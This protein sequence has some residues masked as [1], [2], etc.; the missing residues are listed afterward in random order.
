[1]ERPIRVLTVD[2]HPIV[3][4][5]LATVLNQEADLDVVG[6][7]E[8]GAQAVAAARRLHP[9]VVL[10]DL[11]MPIMDGVEAIQRIQQ[12]TPDTEVIILTT[13]DTDD[14]IFRGVE[15]GAKAYLLK[16]S[17][18][19]EVLRA[20]RMVHRGESLIEP[21]VASRLLDRF[22]QLSKAPREG[23]LSAREVEVVELIAEGIGNK[24]IA[25]RLTIGEST[26]KT[27]LIHIF[28]KLGVKGRAEAVAEAARKG[29]IRL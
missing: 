10:M 20:I 29:I 28:N 17:P 8:D 26:V 24:E 12:D 4:E 7:V 27:H 9:D 5:G 18:P 16:D 25:T 15:A 11:Q 22:T 3:R 2:D 13:Y 19:E 21:K 1:M 14:Y 6:R 23:G